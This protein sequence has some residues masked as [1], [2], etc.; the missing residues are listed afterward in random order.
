MSYVILCYLYSIKFFT[1]FHVQPD[2]LVTQVEGGGAAARAGV[3]RGARLLEVCRAAVVAL[4]HDHLV[5][6]LKTSDPVTVSTFIFVAQ[7][8]KV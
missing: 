1:G 5:D 4:P 7:W 2:G 8:H 3:K 6:L